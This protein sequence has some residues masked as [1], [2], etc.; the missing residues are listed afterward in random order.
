[1][2]CSTLYAL[3]GLLGVFIMPLGCKCNKDLQGFACARIHEWFSRVRCHADAQVKCNQ[4]QT[5]ARTAQVRKQTSV[6]GLVEPG[7]SPSACPGTKDPAL[8]SAR[9]EFHFFVMTYRDASK[10]TN[11]GTVYR[12]WQLLSCTHPRASCCNGNW[13][14]QDLVNCS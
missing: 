12:R 6:Q 2:R 8:N 9:K 7:S 5:Y 1:M 4:E 13:V 3:Q 10:H 14:F 11:D